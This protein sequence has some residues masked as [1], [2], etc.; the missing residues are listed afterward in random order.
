MDPDKLSTVSSTTERRPLMAALV[1][2]RRI[3]FGCTILVGLSTF[4]WITAVCTD[5]WVHIEGGN[6]IHLP[7][8]GR[9][10]MSSES[11]VW[12]ICRYVFQP[13]NATIVLANATST[14]TPRPR[15]QISGYYFTKCTNYLAPTMVNDKPND[16]AYDENVANYVRTMVSFGI[17]SLFVMTMGCGFSTYT[18]RNPRYMFKRL[19]AGI[20]FISTAC[21]FV[22][23][24]VMMSTVDYLRK[25]VKFVYPDRAYHY[26][27]ISFFLAWFVVL[28]NCFAAAAF[29]WYSKK[30]KGDK[31]ATEE[32]GMA[33]EPTII[34]R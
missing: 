34:G 29:L 4:I 16:P 28:V 6:G 17:I 33:D 23:V 8:T 9:Y 5:K 1:L 11:G 13:V 32:L 19:A 26:F 12:Q 31:A 2:E 15:D 30:R 22:V 24:Q 21:T 18:F 20:H 10:L 3:L 27:N 14:T 7:S 25:N